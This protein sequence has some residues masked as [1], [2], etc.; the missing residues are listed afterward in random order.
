MTAQMVLPFG[1]RHDASF[2]NFYGTTNHRVA[3]LLAE[4]VDRPDELF[5]YLMGPKESGKT[6]LAIAALNRFE[7]RGLAAAYLSFEALVGASS[8][9]FGAAL[10]SMASSALVVL[11]DIHCGLGSI[12]LEERF[13]ESFNELRQRQAKLL[14]TSD[15]SADQL[16]LELPDLL[17]RLKSGLTLR[18]AAVDDSDK[19]KVFGD[20]AK[21]LGLDITEEV[22][23]FI[24]RRS[25][26]SLDALLNVLSRLDRAAWAE[27]QKITVPFVKK[28]MEW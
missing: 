15:R 10:D 21:A 9:Q 14:V 17:S 25:P 26:R 16:N 11:E 5:V 22:G 19:L 8:E 27:K 12:E 18:L 6:H 13:F 28:V 4:S 3:S 24:I 20:A 7:E 2:D 23:R 1:T